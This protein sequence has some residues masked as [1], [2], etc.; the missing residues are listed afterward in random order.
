MSKLS[1]A[2]FVINHAVGLSA[3]YCT[4]S[5]IQNNVEIETT[6]DKLK[7]GIGSA[8]IGMMVA[9]QA[10][11]YVGNIMDQVTTAW[12][13]AKQEKKETEVKVESPA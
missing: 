10:S 8:V 4:A 6:N 12:E 9:N 1:I 3:G 7:L 11:D 2:K 13:A 5:V